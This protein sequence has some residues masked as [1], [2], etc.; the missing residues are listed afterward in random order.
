VIIL[1][2]RLILIE[3][4]NNHVTEIETRASKTDSMKTFKIIGQSKP[5]GIISLFNRE[6]F[7]LNSRI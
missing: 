6:D 2:S 7:I 1:A 3:L 4:A 5:N